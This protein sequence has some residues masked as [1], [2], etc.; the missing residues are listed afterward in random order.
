EAIPALAARC[1][2]HPDTA[3]QALRQLL[4]LKIVSRVKRPGKTSLYRVNPLDAW[5][6]RNKG[7]TPT[8]I[9]GA[10]EIK[11]HPLKP[12]V[13]TGNEGVTPTRNKG[14]QS[15]SHEVTPL[16]SLAINFETDLA[17]MEIYAAYP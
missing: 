8:G 6:T 7:V 11:G 4:W 12:D 5:A 16:K 10:P 13:A 14:A 9:K 3:W 15:I 17:V 1:G 2:M